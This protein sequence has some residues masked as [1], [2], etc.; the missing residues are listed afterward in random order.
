MIYGYA[1]VS[2]ASQSL[3]EQINMLKK[4]GVRPKNIYHEHYTGTKTNRPQ[5]DTLLNQLKPNDVLIVVKLDRLARNTREALNVIHDL[6]ENDITIKALEP[7]MTVSNDIGGK[8]M[9]NT[10][11]MVADIERDMIVSRTQAG[12]HQAKMYAKQHGLPYQDGRKKRLQSPKSDKY[13]AIHEYKKSHSATDTAKAF[14]VS[15]RTVFY[16]NKLF[17]NQ[18]SNK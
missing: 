13:K 4:S 1:R 2:T 18:S 14:D 3:T 16:V 10:L 11:L 7:R 12:K 15:R 6:R 8:I 5:F 17:K 9:Y